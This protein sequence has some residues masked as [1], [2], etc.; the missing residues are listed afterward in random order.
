VA[1]M[2]LFLVGLIEWG[3]I[4]MLEGYGNWLERNPEIYKSMMRRMKT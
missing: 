3:F 1:L 2:A 4:A